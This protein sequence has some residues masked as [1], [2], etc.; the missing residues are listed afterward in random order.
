[1]RMYFSMNKAWP[2]HDLR[3]AWRWSKKRIN[4]ATNFQQNGDISKTTP[5]IF[6]KLMKNLQLIILTT[7]IKMKRSICNKF[8]LEKTNV[9]WFTKHEMYTHDVKAISITIF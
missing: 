2:I 7:D 3:P 8:N 4:D 6:L 9:L 5:N 1:M